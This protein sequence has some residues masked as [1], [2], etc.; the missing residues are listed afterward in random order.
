ML[1]GSRTIV[2]YMYIHEIQAFGIFKLL[3]VFL[4]QFGVCKFSAYIEAVCLIWVYEHKMKD[5][6]LVHG[7]TRSEFESYIMMHVGVSFFGCRVR[8]FQMSSKGILLQYGCILWYSLICAEVNSWNIGQVRGL[9]CAHNFHVEC[10]DQWLRLNVKC[11]RCRCSVFPNLDLSALSNLRADSE[12]ERPSSTVVTTT[13]YIRA[14]PLSQS[15][16]LRLHGLLRPVRTGNAGS[17]N[18]EP[19]NENALE[20]AENGGFPA[21]MAPARAETGSNFVEHVLAA[22]PSSPPP[23]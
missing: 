18:I 9:P 12:Q 3:F 11:P 20:V 7:I 21:H 10:I 19:D 14:Q 22:P 4:T 17:G 23:H 8:I 1:P 15:Y 16:R 2:W 6:V 13:Q 5:P